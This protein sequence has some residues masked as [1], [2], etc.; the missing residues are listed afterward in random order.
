M[1]AGEDYH[2]I[3]ARWR[4]NSLK[5]TTLICTTEIDVDA[6]RLQAKL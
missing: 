1:A 5:D 3:N 6:L 4:L 2:E